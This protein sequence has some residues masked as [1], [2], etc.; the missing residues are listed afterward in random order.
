MSIK[1]RLNRE[2]YG[3]SLFEVTLGAALSILLGVFLAAGYLIFFTPVKTLRAA[4]KEGEV[5]RNEVVYIEGS[6]S[7]A[8]S[9]QWMRKRQLLLEGQS[10]EISVVEDELNAWIADG[11]KP[12][13]GADAP[14]PAFLEPTSVNFRLSDG[15]MQIGGP[16]S[17]KAVGY[18]KEVL[19]QVRGGFEK[20]GDRVVFVPTESYLG[21]L[22]LHRIPAA[23]SFLASSL[24]RTQ[25]AAEDVA[26]AWERVSSAVIDGNTLMLTVR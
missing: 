7:T 16:A 6:K 12:A 25:S 18:G 2:L 1:S 26:A 8:R 15:V 21:S 24:A 23:E 11:A 10:A 13:G 3:P 17:H 14:A 9:G 4:P 22:A 20:Q 19:F 5:A